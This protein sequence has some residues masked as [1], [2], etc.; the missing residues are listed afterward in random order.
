MT[1]PWGG[2][3]HRVTKDN[4]SPC[5]EC[6]GPL[7]IGEYVHVHFGGMVIIHCRHVCGG[8]EMIHE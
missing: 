6:G 5:F 3:L 1:D 4:H 7:L 2:K 8:K